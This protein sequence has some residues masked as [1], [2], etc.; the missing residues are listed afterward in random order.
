M[1]PE[2]LLTRTPNPRKWAM[3]LQNPKEAGCCDSKTEGNRARLPWPSALT[4]GSRSA[5][6][7]SPAQPSRP[8]TKLH[9]PAEVSSA[10]ALLSR[11]GSTWPE[12]SRLSAHSA[13]PLALH[14]SRFT[15]V[16]CRCTHTP[17][18]PTPSSAVL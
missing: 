4:S 18:L 8:S 17:V 13:C 14:P 12:S 7:P 2:L 16:P 9:H 5:L 10:C 3:S 15:L 1:L 6:R 11:G